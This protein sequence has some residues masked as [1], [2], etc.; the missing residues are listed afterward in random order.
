VGVHCSGNPLLIREWK[1]TGTAIPKKE[2]TKVWINF[3]LYRG[4]DKI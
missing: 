1:Y 4:S 3:W 2:P